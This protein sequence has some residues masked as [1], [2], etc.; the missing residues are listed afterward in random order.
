MIGQA[1]AATSISTVMNGIAPAARRGGRVRGGADPDGFEGRGQRAQEVHQGA[2]DGAGRDRARLV[3]VSA[4][5]RQKVREVHVVADLEVG[6]P[7]G[8]RGEQFQRGGHH[9]HLC[10]GRALLKL[11][12]RCPRLREARGLRVT[13]PLRSGRAGANGMRGR[14]E[15]D[16]VGGRWGSMGGLSGGG[17]GC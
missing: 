4:A 17:G 1:H 15:V 3:R 5:A 12:Q 7:G 6:V 9:S 14:A 16:G 2:I 8:D 13:L 11:P 10:G